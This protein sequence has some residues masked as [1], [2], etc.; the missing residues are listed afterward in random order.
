MNIAT[1]ELHTIALVCT[2]PENPDWDSLAGLSPLVRTMAFSI[3]KRLSPEIC[4]T[5]TIPE[6]Y[7]NTIEASYEVD[8]ATDD[9]LSFLEGRKSENDLW[10]QELKSSFEIPAH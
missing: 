6:G 5:Y 9:F 3:L 7:N 2:N 1:H 8:R 4:A 10:N